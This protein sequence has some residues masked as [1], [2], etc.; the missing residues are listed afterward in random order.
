MK[1]NFCPRG[2][3]VVR[4]AIQGLFDAHP[5]LESGEIGAQTAMDAG[6]EPEVAICL[7]IE[8]A[9]V[10]LVELA[11]IAVGGRIV[12]DDRLSGTELLAA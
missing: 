7:S 12:Y 2:D 10:R 3:G 8:N 4:Y 11:R 1:V 5:K 9:L 6:P